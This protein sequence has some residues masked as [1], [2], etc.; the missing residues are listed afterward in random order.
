MKLN[1]SNHIDQQKALT[2]LNHLISKCEKIEIRK[3]QVPRTIN[4]NKYLHVCLKYF[5]DETGYTI[6]E[7]KE[8]LSEHAGYTYEKKGHRFR[9]STSDFTKE[10]MIEFIE[11]IRNF[12]QEQLGI[13]VPNSE[14]YLLNQFEIEKQLDL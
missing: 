11:F 12:C 1:L 7:S 14:E 3:V 10:E 4:Q 5:S 13:Y 9:K 8:I 6:N 2:Y